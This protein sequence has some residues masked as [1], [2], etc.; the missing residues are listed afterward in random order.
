MSDR[1][2]VKI[3]G[4]GKYLPP[5]IMTNDEIEALVDTSDDWIRA[6]TGIAQR[7]IA[8]DGESTSTMAV[9]AAR[10][11]L[12]VA[13]VDA[14]ELDLILVATA[15][16]DHLGFPATASLVQEAL[17]A[18][19][20]GAFDLNAGCTGFVYALVTGAQFVLS[21]A[22][23][24]VLVIGSDVM[25]RIVDWTDRTTCVLFGDGAGAVVLEATD[26]PGGLRS[27]VLG[28]DGA[29]A[30]HLIV[31]DGGSR[32]PMSHEV[33]EARGNYLRMN[34]REVFRFA[35]TKMT[36]ALNQTISQAQLC[37]S[38]I[39]LMIPHQANIRIV[40]SARTKLNV[41]DGVM[42]TNVDRYGNTSSASIPVALTE[43][44]S[45]RRL[46]TGD[47]LAMVAFGAGLCWGAAVWQW[48][49]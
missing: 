42:F 18:S 32:V 46:N 14:A 22:Y 3:A 49:S 40:D 33:L 8:G 30:K 43:A 24:R 25:S 12:C 21:G 19:H 23:R 16:P 28:S 38:D 15:T 17:G 36:E 1:P 26:Q 34:G 5:R 9:A 44:L 20:A 37:T 29:G 45:E 4:W 6:R 41:A 11:A 48:N 27:F 13:G 47:H 2:H 10:D 39:Q 35:T 31:P 7:R